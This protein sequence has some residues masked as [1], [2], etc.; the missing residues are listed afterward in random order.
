MKKEDFNIALE[1]NK[2]TISSEKQQQNEQKDGER[3]SRQEFSYQSFM[4][5]FHLPKDV[6]DAENI[7]ATYENGLLALEIP[8]KE[9]AKQKPPRTIQIS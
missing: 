8:K 1:G 5:S 4:R 2:L 3:Y 7:K 6:V 9:E